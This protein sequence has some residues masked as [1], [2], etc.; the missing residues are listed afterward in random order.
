MTKDIDKTIRMTPETLQ[1]YIEKA[2]DEGFEKAWKQAG[3]LDLDLQ[4]ALVEIADLRSKVARYH[5]ALEF[6]AEQVIWHDEKNQDVILTYGYC[7]NRA[8]E[9]L[10]GME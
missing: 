6:C 7:V 2:R 3:Q 4:K 8:R 9:A 10:K 5:E 1:S